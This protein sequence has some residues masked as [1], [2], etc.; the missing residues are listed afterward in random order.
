MRGVRAGR[1]RRSAAGESGGEDGDGAGG[2][3]A[4]A[5]DLCQEDLEHLATL[6][7]EAQH[8]EGEPHPDIEGGGAQRDGIAELAAGTPRCR[9]VLPWA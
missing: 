6:C 4:G 3:A 7:E 8:A 2:P 9:L 5:G 1:T